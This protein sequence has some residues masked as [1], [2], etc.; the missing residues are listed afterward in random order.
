MNRILRFRRIAFSPKYLMGTNVIINSTL[1]SGADFFQQSIHHSVD[2]NRTCR[3]GFV[4]AI[5]GFMST[6]WY[7]LLEGRLVPGIAFLEGKSLQKACDEWRR[8]F[9]QI[10]LLDSCVWPICQSLNFA[11]ISPC[12]RVFFIS[13]VN[14]FYSIGLSYI[15]H[16][17]D[18]Q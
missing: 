9:H 2:W 12:Y 11:W 4:G 15:K 8:K 17:D 3:A 6:K 18:D 13:N 14:F 10:L 7:N 5:M 1:L 16:S